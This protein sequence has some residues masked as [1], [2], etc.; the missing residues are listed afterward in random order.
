MLECK[1]SKL[2]KRMVAALENMRQYGDYELWEMRYWNTWN[3]IKGGQ[4]APSI[5]T[6]TMKGLV[7]RGLVQEKYDKKRP[8]YQWTATLTDTGRE[9][10]KEN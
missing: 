1:L 3:A 8:L 10:L 7:K 5:R 2:S 6:D 9:Y 4:C